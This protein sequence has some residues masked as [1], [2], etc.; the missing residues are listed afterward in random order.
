MKVFENMV[1]RKIFGPKGDEVPA[2]YKTCIKGSFV[3]CTNTKCHS[4]HETKKN[5]RGEARNKYA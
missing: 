5:E 1:L 4:G 3:I 2:D